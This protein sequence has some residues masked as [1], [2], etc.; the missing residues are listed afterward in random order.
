MRT[1]IV[2]A[3]LVLNGL[4]LGAQ[5]PS[6]LQQ[7]TQDG[8]LAPLLKNLGTLHVP[9]TTKS[10]DAQRYFDQGMRLVYGFNHA[11]AVRSFREAARIDPGCAMTY[12]G[13]A[14]AL[15]PNINDPA[16]GPD[17]E[18]QGYQAAREAVLRRPGA[19]P[20]EQ[21]L[22]NAI[23]SRFARNGPSG[24]DR[25][26]LN[27]AYAQAMRQAAARF[28]DDPDIAVLYADAVMNTR[29]WDYWTRDGQP[30]P[31]IADAR[32]ALEHAIQL[33]PD[34]PGARHI[35]IHLMEA[36]DLVDL[37]VPSADRL[38]ALMPGAGHLVH[39]P[40]HVYIRVGRYGDA[41]ESN[42]RAIRADEDYITQCRAQGI[43]PAAYYPHNIHFLTAALVMQ[44]R[45][46]DAL[47]AARK[48]AVKHGHD[49]P[50]DG[51]MAFAQLLDALPFLTMVRFGMWDALEKESE[52][53]SAAAFV[54]SIHQF[55]R[56]MAFS[57]TGRPEEATQALKRCEELAAT[58]EVRR[59]KILDLN[60]LSEIARIG[61]SMLRGDIEQKAGRHP[62]AVTAFQHAVDIE[63]ALLYSEPPDWFIPPR[64]YLAHALLSAGQ[65]AEAERVYR[66]DL[67]RHRGNGWSLRGLE[68]SLR[69]QG[70]TSQADQVHNQFQT[71]WRQA[72]VQ[73]TGSRF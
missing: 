65:P 8:R 11:E 60:P 51:L 64:Q 50:G 71:A 68:V 16:I 70:R 32:A 66:Q 9:V 58:E 23:A 5:A 14:L 39:M 28:P 46:A 22:I 37:A 62:A 61:A 24:G 73:L 1:I 53:H 54:R 31:G 3:T 45:G 20:R 40:S 41:A 57:A 33:H 7:T 18:Q 12:W 72:D 49:M 34:H 59:L 56:G 42:I 44:G 67:K 35:Y 30:Q 25:N 47:S 36:S 19:T 48:S 52:P 26:A 21:V 10:A 2:L 43:Y 13:Q 4:L 69:A 29:P 63:D 27:T 15:S 38:G 17:R 6:V 55:G